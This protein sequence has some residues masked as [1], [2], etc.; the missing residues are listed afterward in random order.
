[1]CLQE[2]VLLVSILNV[3]TVLKIKMSVNY[4]KLLDLELVRPIHV[5]PVLTLIVSFVMQ[6][7]LFALHAK[8]DMV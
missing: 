8:Q 2:A 3:R 7:L 4:V 6:I 5:L 1:M